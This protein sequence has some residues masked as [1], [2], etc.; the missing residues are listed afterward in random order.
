M[1]NK[2]AEYSYADNSNITNDGNKGETI[3]YNNEAIQLYKS[4]SGD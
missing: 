4:K 1:L 3:T 2:V